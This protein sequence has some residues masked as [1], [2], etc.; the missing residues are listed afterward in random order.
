[1]KLNSIDSIL[2]V[3]IPF[4]IIILFLLIGFLL[5]RIASASLRKLA[6][7][8]TKKWDDVLVKSLKGL[9]LAAFLLIGLAVAL[10]TVALAPEISRFVVKFITLAG[11]FFVLLFASR[12][13][14]GFFDLYAERITGV[15][16]TIFKN[17]AVIIIYVLGFLIMLDYL[18]ISI[19]PIITA[20]GV[21]GLAVAFALQDTLS[22]LFSG[23]HILMTKK[24]RPGD[25]V[26]LDSG[27]EGYVVDITWRNTTIRALANN[28]IVVPNKKLAESI[29][30]N[31]DLPEREMA[32]LVD[33][34]VSYDTDLQKAEKVILEVA[35][36]AMRSIPGAVAE[37][38]PFI[39]YNL[40]GDSGIQCTVIL[41]AKEF[42]SQYLIKHEF[43]K[44]LHARF[45]KEGIE[46]PFPARKVYFQKE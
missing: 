2:K 6:Q 12:I 3:L 7:K 1:M 39:R 13:S 19:T 44:E 25:Y 14:R 26:K 23:L 8:T 24:I 11:I 17:I 45:K 28:I 21:G 46:I 27:D 15:P 34:S 31:F 10:K 30:V 42:V 5:Q 41:R 20:L 4:G 22:N 36:E 29:V 35:K 18:G 33:V 37:F 38:E 16:T 32:V 43:I 9:I 40:F